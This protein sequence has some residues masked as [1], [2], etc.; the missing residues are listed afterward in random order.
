MT[1][2][3]NLLNPALR[4]TRDWLTATPLAL[5]CVTLL[6]LVVVGYGAARV[7]ADG[8]EREAERLSAQLKAAQARL[9]ETAKA[10][11]ARK[12]NAELLADVAN[13]R[14]QLQARQGLMTVL[15][16]G[17]IGN[18]SGFSAY[19]R[20]FARQVPSGLWLTGFTIDAGGSAMEIRGRMLDPAAL[21]EY[22]RRLNSE[23]AF[24]G[25]SF[26]TLSIRRPEDKPGAAV[27]GSSAAE[28]AGYVDFVL[29]QGA[30]AAAE[31]MP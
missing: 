15:A 20:G 12:P 10:V 11:A 4:R 22:I 5:V 1:Q 16:S 7:R 19:L 26:A 13:A 21:P 31:K 25:R 14:A 29:A 18:T 28:P 30:S 8:R 3:I 6:A 23:P 27:P 17:A 9:V 2:Q 24:Q